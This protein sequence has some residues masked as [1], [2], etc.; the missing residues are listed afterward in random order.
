[1]EWVE[2][3]HFEAGWWGDCANTL[4]EQ[5]KHPTYARMM[6]TPFTNDGG[7]YV[8]DK[9]GQSILDIGGGPT[10]MLLCT[11][12][13]RRTVVDPCPYPQ[14]TRDRYEA[15]GIE[16]VGSC[17]EDF[18]ADQVY[19]EA[20]CYNVLQHVRDPR[21][22]IANMRRSARLIRMF[23][24][25][26]EPPHEGHPHELKSVELAE[27]GGFENGWWA[28]APE[29]DWDHWVGGDYGRQPAFHGYAEVRA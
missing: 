28:E 8:I 4:G 10:S 25:V 19:D 18:V 13:D 21:E 14:W 1:M 24:W 23:E 27:W 15:A 22:V 29:V 7:R 17:G 2:P 5:F 11:W 26:N 9:R 20:W 3:Q 6:G 12:A 16:L